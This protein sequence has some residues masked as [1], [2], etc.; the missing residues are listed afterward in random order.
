M[1]D[2]GIYLD[3]A[4]SAPVRPEARE[5][6]LPFL[7]GRFGNPSSIHRYGRE[8]RAA[9][10]EARAR[11]AAVIGASPQE[12]VFTRAG[13]EADGVAVLGRA[14]QVRGA[15]VAVS[16]IEHKAVLASAHA[17]EEE[18]ARVIVLPVDGNGVVRL[19]AVDEALARRP[20]VVSVMW[21]NNEVGALQ[22]V[23][24]IGARCRAAGVVFHSDAVQALGKVPVRADQAAVDLLAFSAHKVGGPK[25]IGALYVRRGTALKPLLFGGG[26][27][28]GLRPGTEDVAGAVG[29]AA[30]AY[31]AEAEREQA[32][33]RIGALRGR[34]EAGLRE[35][36]PGLV[37]N[38]AGAPRLPTVSNVSVPGADPEALLMSLD[39]E[40]IAAS[41]GSACSSGAVEP[42]HVLTAMG[43]AREIAG[44]SVRFSLGW[45]TT[46]AEIGRVLEVFPAIV[47]RVRE[48]GGSA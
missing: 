11:L 48:S 1:T 29:F 47:E 19:G 40:G 45:G 18:G 6:M 44:P 3:Y 39:L 27:E 12:I 42:S 28:R 7:E 43:I 33:A 24:E 13:T 32:M 22:P 38:A 26:Q 2:T 10:E 16:A 37:V 30:A 34:L 4:A 9:L 46:D 36:V 5:A 20:A 8:A 25:G 35:R 14:R 17:A 23:G 41:S 15:P 21:A 31:A